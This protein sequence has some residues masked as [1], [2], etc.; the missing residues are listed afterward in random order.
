MQVWKQEKQP[1]LNEPNEMNIRGVES[2]RAEKI[3]HPTRIDKTKKNMLIKIEYRT[4]HRV[5]AMSA[6]RVT[7]NPLIL[8]L[9][10]YICIFFFLSLRYDDE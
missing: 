8:S 2:E 4:L 5:L 3:S 9:P 6:P 10:F 7:S 1:E